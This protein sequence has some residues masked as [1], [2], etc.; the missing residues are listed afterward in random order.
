MYSVC[1]DDS[2]EGA[3]SQLGDRA[4]HM[5]TPGPY[6]RV[7]PRASASTRM[8]TQTR[9]RNRP[10]GWLRRANPSFE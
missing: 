1:D 9:N 2:G 8:S 10:K 3:S 5:L 7:L 6:Q 4:E